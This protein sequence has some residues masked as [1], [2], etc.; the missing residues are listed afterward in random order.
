M[1]IKVTLDWI[2]LKRS[3]CFH[4]GKKKQV[5]LEA[6][7]KVT[8]LEFPNLDSEPELFYLF[9]IHCGLSYVTTLISYH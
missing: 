6:D 9:C 5:S 2:M 8:R 7:L 4:T 1:V 3:F